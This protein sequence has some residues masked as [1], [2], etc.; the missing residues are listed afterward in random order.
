MSFM[1]L[2]VYKKDG[3]TA[4]E[5]LDLPDKIFN[6]EPNDH[7]IYQAV[8]SYMINNRQGTVATKNRSKVRGG[9]KKPWRQKGRGVARAGTSRSPLWVGGGRTFGPSPRDFSMR[10]PQ[11][12]KL[13]AKKS[14][15]TYKAVQN[16]IV[17]IEDFTLDE[18]KTRNIF[19][20][21]KNNKLD[22]K[23]VLLVTSDFDHNILVAGRN[24]PNLSIRTAKDLCTYDILDCQVMLLQKSALDKIKE[25][26]KV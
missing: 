6:I 17:V 1:E 25:V 5:K 15:F 24:I 2:D 21:L 14:A 13:L 23:K 3:I 11:K 4:G 10:L 12:I 26:C 22:T 8:R 19:S 7:A 9:G 20:I 18:P 16:E